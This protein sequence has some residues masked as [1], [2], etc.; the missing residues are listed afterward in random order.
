MLDL[1]TKGIDSEPQF[2]NEEIKIIFFQRKLRLIS[3]NKLL[4][5]HYSSK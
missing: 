2:S 5:Q 4:K 3:F 1:R